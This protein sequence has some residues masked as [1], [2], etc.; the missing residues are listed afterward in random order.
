MTRT[1]LQSAALGVLLTLSLFAFTQASDEDGDFTNEF[2]ATIRG[3]ETE[4]QEVLTHLEKRSTVRVINT[5]SIWI[6][7]GDYSVDT[8][9]Y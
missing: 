6:F 3:G 2:V 7:Y 9:S 4:L 5:V 8:G 1:L